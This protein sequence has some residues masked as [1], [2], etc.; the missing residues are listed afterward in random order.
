MP[1]AVGLAAHLPESLVDQVQAVVPADRMEIR[2]QA[3]VH[4]H[5]KA[6]ELPKKKE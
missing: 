4:L 3:A 5:C 1:F 2:P 6:Y